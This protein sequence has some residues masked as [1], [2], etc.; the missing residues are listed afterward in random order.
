MARKSG[1]TANGST[2]KK[3]AEKVTIVKVARSDIGRGD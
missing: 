2:T 3:T 1:M